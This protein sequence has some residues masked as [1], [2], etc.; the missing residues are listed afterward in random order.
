MRRSGASVRPPGTKGARHAGRRVA[1]KMPTSTGPK[2][3]HVV[4]DGTTPKKAGHAGAALKCHGVVLPNTGRS[5]IVPR[6]LRHFC[7]AIS[8][9]RRMTG[10]QVRHRP[11][12]AAGRPAQ[13]IRVLEGDPGLPRS[14]M[15]RAHA[16][17]LL[18]RQQ[19]HRNPELLTTESRLGAIH[20]SR[21]VCGA[22]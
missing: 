6:N 11:Q 1:G 9:R 15:P 3:F 7:F 19:R 22:S 2:S 18:R 13:S 17:P 8:T 21:Q 10:A 4:Q 14:S 12:N 20:A 16:S 5:A